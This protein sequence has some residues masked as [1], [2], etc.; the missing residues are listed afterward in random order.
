MKNYQHKNRSQIFV[1]LISMWF[2]VTLVSLFLNPGSKILA[3]SGASDID[4]A[5]RNVLGVIDGTVDANE[6][7]SGGPFSLLD[8]VGTPVGTYEIQ[9]YRNALGSIEEIQFF[10]SITDVSDNPDI[11]EIRIRFDSD[12][13]HSTINGNPDESDRT[14]RIIR[15]VSGGGG[16]GDV[17]I[18]QM[19][20]S[21]PGTTLSNLN[22]A[23]W[24]I[25]GASNPW[26]AEV[27]LDSSD[28][29][30][31]YIPNLMG[32]HINVIRSSSPS[33]IDDSPANYP[34]NILSTSIAQWANIKTR[35]PMNYALVLD[36]SGSMDDSIDGTS[37]NFERWNSAIIASEIFT[38]LFHTFSGNFDDRIGV[39]TFTSDLPYYSGCGN[40][41]VVLTSGANFDVLNTIVVDD[42]VVNQIGGAVPANCTPIKGALNHTFDEINDHV[43]ADNIILLLS[44]GFHNS[45]SSNY[46]DTVYDY[47]TSI[48]ADFEVNTVALESETD[49]NAD[50]GL[51]HDISLDFDG[52]S[53]I[54]HDAT[55][56][57]EVIDSFADI[58]TDRLYVNRTAVNNLTGQFTVNG[59]EPNLTVMLVWLT[60]VMDPRNFRLKPPST[61]AITPSLGDASYPTAIY[62]Q[63][64]NTTAGLEYEVAYYQIDN[65]ELGSWTIW[66]EAAD[67]PLIADNNLALFDPNV[68]A[69]FNAKRSG[70]NILLTAPLKEA[71][72][73]MLAPDANV[74]VKVSRPDEGIGTVLSTLQ[75]DCRIAEPSLPNIDIIRSAIVTGRNKLNSTQFLDL[76]KLALF[77]QK[78]SSSGTVKVGDQLPLHMQKLDA[79]FNVCEKVGF[80]R[81]DN[82]LQLY[83][84]GSHGDVVANDGIHSLLLTDTDKEGTYIFDFEAKGNTPSGSEFSRVRKFS[85]HKSVNVFN[86]GTLIG[87]R[88]LF[89]EGDLV[90]REYY[91][92]PLSASKEYLGPGHLSEV[93]YYVDNSKPLGSVND[94][95]NG[96]YSQ[97]VQYQKS[98]GEPTVAVV[99]QGKPILPKNEPPKPVQKHSDLFW[100]VLFIALILLLLLF[101][102][103]RSKKQ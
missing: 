50:T 84:D 55:S 24:N 85:Y 87:D 60:T 58:L 66:Q 17:L 35:D 32:M 92:L 1:N 29:G 52:Q 21:L 42:Y 46:T 59:D 16:V 14:V 65:P 103:Y 31:G 69:R 43:D 63:H 10:F 4:A 62:H 100:I 97:I 53:A 86:F 94:Y 79:L 28:L 78:A 74:T 54:Y 34:Q 26:T 22:A 39:L 98:Q 19:D 13:S 9:T 49:T 7:V 70:E 93:N 96:Y 6:Y 73:P 3:D 27:K 80:N 75:F 61:N 5:K 40:D 11:D 15:N 41:D 47:N 56:K 91:V 72:N 12:H 82:S 18:A 38:Q 90:T 99:V 36:R 76:T 23:N 20:T 67:S 88:I 89:E 81:S 68:Y 8:G 95:L 48:Q 30:L 2:L 33:S 102:C 57:A 44:D 83:D 64:R 45:P 101:L 25:V 51:L 37:N 77:N 71:G